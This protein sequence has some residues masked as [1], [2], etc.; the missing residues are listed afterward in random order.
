[1]QRSV[2]AAE[3]AAQVARDTLIAS[4]RPWVRVNLKLVSDIE[5]NETGAMVTVL[6]IFKNIGKSPAYNVYGRPSICATTNDRKASNIIDEADL[7][8]PEIRRT[9]G[10]GYNLLPDEEAEEAYTLVLTQK[11]I[12]DGGFGRSSIP[13]LERDGSQT[14]MALDIYGV[15]RYSDQIT[16]K[17]HHTSFIRCVRRLDGTGTFHKYGPAIRLAE[18]CLVPHILNA[19]VLD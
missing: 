15:I 18:I 11:E 19:K 8:D 5:Y 2:L 10:L 9:G 7:R 12:A 13:G 1:M 17:W 16:E 4:N 6:L 3:T 14:H